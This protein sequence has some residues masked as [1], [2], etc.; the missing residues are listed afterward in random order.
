[1][2]HGL[3]D[4]EMPALRRPRLDQGARSVGSIAT[5]LPVDPTQEHYW[6]RPRCGGS[7]A[8]L[9]LYLQFGSVGALTAKSRIREFT[10]VVV[11]SRNRPN[12]RAEASDG[13]TTNGVRSSASPPPGGVRG[14][15]APLYAAQTPA[16]LVELSLD[17]VEALLHVHDGGLHTGHTGLKR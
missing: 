15:Q 17:A 14:V 13:F 9:G 3:R 2:H 1:M 7:P 16:H 10:T 6:C 8:D 11:N 5:P 12:R 4:K